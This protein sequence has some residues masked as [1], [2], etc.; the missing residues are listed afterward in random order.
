MTASL[1]SVCVYCGSREGHD[2][3]FR[4]AAEEFGAALAERR[5]RLVYGGG[6]VGLMGRLADAVLA[7][8]GEV[9]GVIPEA[10]VN[11][12]LAH[13][14]VTDMRVV[15]SMHA[16]KALMAEES[17][18]FV[19]LPGG[20]GTFEE[21]CEVLTWAQLGF[22][23]KPTAVLNVAGYYD[24]LAALL[25]RAVAHDFMS[26]G[27]RELATFCDTVPHLLEYLAAHMS[28]DEPVDPDIG[29]LT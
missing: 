6:N 5:W 29:E 26:A 4:A 7:G 8:G 15:P 9:T 17:H 18:S 2:S 19:A 12:E 3:R 10:L 20:L 27:N 1:K 16:R 11:R 13:S 28:T 24:P 21:L 25:D 14:G 23:H 22:H